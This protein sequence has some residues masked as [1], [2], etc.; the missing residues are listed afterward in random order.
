MPRLVPHS[1]G[2]INSVILPGGDF[3]ALTFQKPR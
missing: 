2:E 3:Y 1:M